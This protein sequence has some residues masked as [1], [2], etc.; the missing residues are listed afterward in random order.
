MRGPAAGC[1]SR[2]ARILA[3]VSLVLLFAVAAC[4][5]PQKEAE[6]APRGDDAGRVANEATADADRD[7]VVV[8]RDIAQL[9][10]TSKDRPLARI[11]ALVSAGDGTS[12]LFAVDM[13]GA[14]HVLDNG[15]LL[16]ALFL[17]MTKARAAAFVHNDTEK[18]LASIAFHP[19]YARAGAVSR[20]GG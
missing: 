18:G 6:P 3:F 20:A 8:V 11:N 9:P 1:G 13:D 19:D 10:V 2:C 14:V 4:G 5:D 16:P 17:D 15:Q 12:R 7:V